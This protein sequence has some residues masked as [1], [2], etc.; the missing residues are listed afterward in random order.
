MHQKKKDNPRDTTFEEE[1]SLWKSD[2]DNNPIVQSHI[3]RI[4]GT[5]RWNFARLDLTIHIQSNATKTKPIAKPIILSIY[6][7][8]E[9]RDKDA[10]EL[11]A[12]GAERINAMGHVPLANVH[13]V[14]GSNVA[15]LDIPAAIAK[16]GIQHPSAIPK[17]LAE[18][19]L[20]EA[21]HFGYSC[22]MP[23]INSR[24]RRISK[25]A[26]ERFQTTL[27]SHYLR[28]RFENKMREN[29]S[30][31]SEP[32]PLDDPDGEQTNARTH[33]RHLF[34]TLRPRTR[35]GVRE[36]DYPTT[37]NDRARDQTCGVRT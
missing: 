16:T 7:T 12:L 34:I 27:T 4:L 31:H 8:L 6:K 23:S 19:F 24:W 14:E 37:R 30:R 17:E 2:D 11:M 25:I 20:D 9:R 18:Q 3:G 36:R 33:A 21:Q 32:K 5:F 26:K 22:I 13:L 15:L 28:K 29:P 10:L 35:L 1:L